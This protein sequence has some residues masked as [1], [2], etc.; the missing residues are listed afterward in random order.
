[1][2]K[3]SVIIPYHKKISFIKKSLNSA[4]NQTYQNKEIIIIFDDNNQEELKYN[5]LS[6]RKKYKINYKLK[7]F[8]SGFI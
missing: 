1:M 5:Y 7:K 6:K 4:L 8:R 3:I 2:D